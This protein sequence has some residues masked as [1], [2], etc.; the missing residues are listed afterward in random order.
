MTA[1]FPIAFAFATWKCADCR[2]TVEW[3]DAIVCEED[4]KLYAIR[5]KG[6]EA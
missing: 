6:C 2:Q 3:E 1:G 5:H 4:G